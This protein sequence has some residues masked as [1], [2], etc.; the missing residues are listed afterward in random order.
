VVASHLTGPAVRGEARDGWARLELRYPAEGA[1][2]ASLLGFG[3]DVEVLAPGTLRRDLR[4]S[5]AAV[6]ALYDSDN[7]L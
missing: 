5:A 7:G 6:V 1:P 2:R 4:R 3:A